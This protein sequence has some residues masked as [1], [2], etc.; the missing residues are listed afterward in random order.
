MVSLND[1]Q[2]KT[3][4]LWILSRANGER[5]RLTSDPADELNP[6]WSPDGKWIFFTANKSGDRFVA[7]PPKPLCKLN[8]EDEERR[9]RY[10]VGKDGLFF[11]VLK[12]NGN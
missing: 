12:N 7:G 11:V 3:R 1:P 6:I 9:N 4:D 2:L 5:R 8:V 10:L